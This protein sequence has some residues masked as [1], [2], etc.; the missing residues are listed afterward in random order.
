[1]AFY[2]DLIQLQYILLTFG[3]ASGPFE[4]LPQNFG[5]F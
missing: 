3:F 4:S 1:M 5:L 2:L